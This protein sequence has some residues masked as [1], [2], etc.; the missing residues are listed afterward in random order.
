[1]AEFTKLDTGGIIFR[2]T[3][4]ASM[5]KS[6]CRFPHVT[7]DSNCNIERCG[8]NCVQNADSRCR[9]VRVLLYL[10]EDLSLGSPPRVMDPCTS[11]KQKWGTGQKR[12]GDSSEIYKHRYEKKLDSERYLLFDPRPADFQGTSQEEKHDFIRN[13]QLYSGSSMW[14]SILQFRYED[15]EL[16]P[17]RM[18]TLRELIEQFE[19]NLAEAIPT[20]QDDP[21]SNS[22]CVHVTVFV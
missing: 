10:I 12:K 22:T 2:G 16:T 8:C 13:L 14:S 4:E 18:D 19:I 9:H 11:Q 3:V 15:Y 5:K 1:M 7:L 20:Y 6:E 17:E 21:L